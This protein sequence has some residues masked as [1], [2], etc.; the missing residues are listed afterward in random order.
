MTSANSWAAASII[1]L[2]DQTFDLGPTSLKKQYHH[3]NA[4]KLFNFM[5]SEVIFQYSTSKKKAQ[6]LL[7]KA[8]RTAYVRSPASEFQ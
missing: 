7:G 2:S 1:S 5:C 8:N 4:M 3:H 6:L